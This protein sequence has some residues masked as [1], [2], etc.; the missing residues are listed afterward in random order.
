MCVLVTQSIS[1]VCWSTESPL[2]EDTAPVPTP[3]LPALSE[4]PRRLNETT[5]ATPTLHSDKLQKENQNTPQLINHPFLLSILPEP[6]MLS[7]AEEP[8]CS[9]SRESPFCPLSRFLRLHHSL[10]L[11]CTLPFPGM[12]PPSPPGASFAEFCSELSPFSLCVVSINIQ[13]VTTPT[14]W[15]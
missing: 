6:F 15:L 2:G 11:T 7:D 12:R 8:H 4:T 3:A 14:H 9:G 5:A 13:A 1:G 10:A